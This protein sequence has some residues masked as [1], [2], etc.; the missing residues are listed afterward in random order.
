MATSRSRAAATPTSRRPCGILRPCAGGNCGC[1]WPPWNRQCHQP[2][3]TWLYPQVF[4]V[5]KRRYAKSRL[6]IC[7]CDVRCDMRMRYANAICEC[8]M[9]MRYAIC[10]CDMRM[11]Y[12]ICD[13]RY[14]ICDMRYAIC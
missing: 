13:M 11:R 14:A 9:R 4:E 10:E 12:A 7:E 1:S 3:S 5:R 6:Q 8:D 2:T